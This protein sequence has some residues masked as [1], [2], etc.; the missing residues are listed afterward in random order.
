MSISISCR[1]TTTIAGPRLALTD[2]R[3]PSG[4][5]EA[6]VAEGGAAA[7]AFRADRALQVYHTGAD[8]AL[9]GGDTLLATW[10]I[11]A[12]ANAG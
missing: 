12:G 5:I 10:H 6:L 9:D 7:G 8:E 4:D 2:S 3:S 11:T 1:F